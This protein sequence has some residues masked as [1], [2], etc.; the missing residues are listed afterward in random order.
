MPLRGKK[1]KYFFQKTEKKLSDTADL[2]Q[3]LK[4]LGT[5]VYFTLTIDWMFSPRR[6]KAS[7]TCRATDCTALSGKTEKPDC[8]CSQENI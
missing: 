8:H 1:C 7:P 6:G 4:V 2:Q 3:H 5:G